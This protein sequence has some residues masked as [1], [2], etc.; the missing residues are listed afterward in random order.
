MLL[1]KDGFVSNIAILRAKSAK[2][3]SIQGTQWPIL[4][5][6]A[7]TSRYA[8]K[9][10]QKEQLECNNA[11]CSKIDWS[12]FEANEETCNTKKTTT[13]IWDSVCNFDQTIMEPNRF[14]SRSY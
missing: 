6:K 9:F 8:C 1:C 11:L 2:S 12:K 13:P 14:V 4:H 3:R 7:M 10:A 5:R